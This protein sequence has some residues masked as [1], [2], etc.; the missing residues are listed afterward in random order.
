LRQFEAINFVD[1]SFLLHFFVT[2]IKT[3]MLQYILQRIY[4]LYHIGVK[5]YNLKRS[6][7]ISLLIE[8]LYFY[9][10]H[11]ILYLATAG[12]IFCSIDMKLT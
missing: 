8:Q 10:K 7:V 3:Y 9:K 5:C 2:V 4:N 11:L 12:N 1:D 6:Y